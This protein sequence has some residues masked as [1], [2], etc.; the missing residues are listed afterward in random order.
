MK[1]TAGC[2]RLCGKCV[3]LAAVAAAMATVFMR[4][5]MKHVKSAGFSM[6]SLPLS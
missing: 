1:R 3:W 6:A 5:A 2:C 4:I